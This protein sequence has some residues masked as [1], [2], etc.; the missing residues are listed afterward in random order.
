[1]GPRVQHKAAC[2]ER[3]RSTGSKETSCDSFLW[4]V[5]PCGH[6]R[7]ILYTGPGRSPTSSC[8]LPENLLELRGGL[9]RLSAYV[10][11]GLNV[12]PEPLDISTRVFRSLSWFLSWKS[13]VEVSRMVLRVW[14]MVEA[15]LRSSSRS[16]MSAME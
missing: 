4:L 12:G 8:L 9:A 11:A 3:P 7:G 1:M 5:R 13:S 2:G 16:R 14:T 10:H 15:N 6:P